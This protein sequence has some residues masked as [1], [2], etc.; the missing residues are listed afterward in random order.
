VAD[1]SSKSKTVVSI[2]GLEEADPRSPVF[3]PD[4]DAYWERLAEIED[5]RRAREADDAYFR[6][7]ER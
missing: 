1:A 6:W 5:E 3:D 2:N 7:V 4:C